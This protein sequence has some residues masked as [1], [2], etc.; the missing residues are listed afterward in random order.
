M[1]SDDCMNLF[2]ALDGKDT[3]GFD[4]SGLGKEE[5]ELALFLAHERFPDN[6]FL[7][8]FTER[9]RYSDHGG[10]GESGL[11]LFKRDYDFYFGPQ[12]YPAI[13]RELKS[14]VYEIYS[15]ILLANKRLASTPTLDVHPGEPVP[16][17]LASIGSDDQKSDGE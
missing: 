5:Q 10:D 3:F 11:E 9:C 2:S 6:Q 4:S 7:S 8:D 13:P 15:N 12:E 17:P 1:F 16:L 14:R